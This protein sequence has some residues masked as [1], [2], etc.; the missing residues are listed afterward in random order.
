MSF[1]VLVASELL[2]RWNAKQI[3]WQAAVTMALR[4]LAFDLA[5]WKFLMTP[6]KKRN[7][8]S[9]L[10]LTGEIS[11]NNYRWY[12][13]VSRGI[14]KSKLQIFVHSSVC[15]CNWM[16]WKRGV[17]L[18]CSLC[19]RFCY[20]ATLGSNFCPLW[21]TGL[22]APTNWLT[23]PLSLVSQQLQIFVHTSVCMCKG[24]RGVYY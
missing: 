10:T 8:F 9:V 4:F 14:W 19:G 24:G 22:R 21:L 11:K 1:H 2:Q 23:K 18:N 15:M 16:R 3:T 5:L 6:W 12:E 17:L 13:E 7:K 20:L